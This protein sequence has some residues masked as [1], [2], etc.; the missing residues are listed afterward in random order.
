MIVKK[1]KIII[2]LFCIIVLAFIGIKLVSNG[3]IN[4]ANSISVSSPNMEN[5]ENGTYI[6]ECSCTPVYVKVKVIV[7]NHKLTNIT[8]LEHD[9]GLGSSA[10][11][12]IEDIIKNQS[13]DVDTVSG[14]TVS[15]KCILKAVENATERGSNQI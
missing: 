14:A 15:S 1:K 13:L 11:G 2:I 6:G 9:N 8:I 5:I 4:H 7:K 12:I 10:E 3:L